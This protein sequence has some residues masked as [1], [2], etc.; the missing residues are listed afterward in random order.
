MSKHNQ[1]K[2]RNLRT[3]TL[4]ANEPNKPNAGTRVVAGKNPA[5]CDD[6]LGVESKKHQTKQTKYEAFEVKGAERKAVNLQIPGTARRV[7]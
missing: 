6:T 3:I 5:D 1:P 4:E 7:K 2:A